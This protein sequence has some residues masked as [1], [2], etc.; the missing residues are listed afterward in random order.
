[1]NDRESQPMGEVPALQEKQALPYPLREGGTHWAECWRSPGHHNCA[2]VMVE[3]L[4]TDVRSVDRLLG[5]MPFTG[6][7]LAAAADI[8]RR[9]RVPS[10]AVT[11]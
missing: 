9:W 4:L 1:M 5:A 11:A 2:V 7:H 6:E 10:A 3:E 8:A